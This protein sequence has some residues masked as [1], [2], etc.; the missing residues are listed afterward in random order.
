MKYP[1]LALNE[2]MRDLH[3]FTDKHQ[4]TIDAIALAADQVYR[5]KPDDAEAVVVRVAVEVLRKD[6]VLAQGSVAWEVRPAFTGH[7]APE[8][9]E[10]A[11]EQIR[12]ALKDKKHV[13]DELAK[14]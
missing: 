9:E 11:R 10:E 2:L 7:A 13:L 8:T 1:A 3:A 14:H 6:R 5:G 4:E 12:R